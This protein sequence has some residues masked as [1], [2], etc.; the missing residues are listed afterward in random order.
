MQQPR[1]G[2]GGRVGLELRGFGPRWGMEPGGGPTSV[3]AG[4]KPVTGLRWR[5][6]CCWAAG[7]GSDSDSDAATAAGPG[8]GTRVEEE[9]SADSV[10]SHL[11][12]A[13][14]H[15]GHWQ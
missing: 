4:E 8:D 14:D 11:I 15:H 1:Q 7:W 5:D 10:P 9:V 6:R 12:T 13:S 3:R 2:E